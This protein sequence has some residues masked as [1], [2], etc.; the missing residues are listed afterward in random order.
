[1]KSRKS[2]GNCRKY[3]NELENG[4]NRENYYDSICHP[5]S[6]HVGEGGKS[7]SGEIRAKSSDSLRKAIRVFRRGN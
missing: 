5:L 1:M 6:L 7:V 4:N 3:G 2:Q